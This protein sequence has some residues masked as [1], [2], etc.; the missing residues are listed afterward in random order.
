MELFV[1]GPYGFN[2]SVAPI[3]GYC[4]SYR[5]VRTVALE[6]VEIPGYPKWIP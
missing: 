1:G 4:M 6:E 2:A 3:E 5:R